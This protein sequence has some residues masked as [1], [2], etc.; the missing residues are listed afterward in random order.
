[1]QIPNASPTAASASS[2]LYGAA[3]ADACAQLNARLEPYRA[4]MPDASFKDLVNAAYVER[5]DLSA[6]GFYSTP[7]I[8]GFG[9]DTPYNYFCYGARTGLEL[10]VGKKGKGGCCRGR[11]AGRKEE[12]G[13]EWTS[14][15]SRTG[16][17]QCI[18]PSLRQPGIA[19][20]VHRTPTQARRRQRWR[21]TR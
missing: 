14:S 2:D 13:K 8:G 19:Q 3:A 17:G 5:V 15:S 7:G 20:P 6:H 9:S 16:A 4:K 12:G 21:W 1:M 18:D 10:H 11:A